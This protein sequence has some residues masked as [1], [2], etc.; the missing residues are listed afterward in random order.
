MV[1]VFVKHFV[2][3]YLVQVRVKDNMLTMYQK[4][5]RV[6]ILNRLSYIVKYIVNGVSETHIL[7]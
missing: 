3:V 6:A 2:V 4:M 1:K 5:S 7:L